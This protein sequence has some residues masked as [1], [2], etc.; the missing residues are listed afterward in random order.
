MVFYV[1]VSTFWNQLGGVYVLVSTLWNQLG[2]VYVLVST[3]WNQMGGVYVL[4]S[5]FS[6]LIPEIKSSVVYLLFNLLKTVKH[7]KY[8]FY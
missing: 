5:T 1:L 4:V 3:F 6:F 2:G 7:N 8:G